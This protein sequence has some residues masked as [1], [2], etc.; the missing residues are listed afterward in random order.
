MTTATPANGR[1]KKSL[2]HQLDRLDQILD[3]LAEALNGAV[4][5]AV[6]EAVGAAVAEAVRAA[7]AEVL[8][9]PAVAALLA[10]ARAQSPETPAPTGPARWRDRL[11]AGC[12]RAWAVAAA[13]PAVCGWVTTT[14]RSLTGPVVRATRAAA[15]RVR[16]LRAGVAVALVVLAAGRRVLLP[17]AGAGLAAG[18]GCY[19][20][21]P[22]A[23]GL[24][25]GLAGAAAVAAAGVARP[26]WPLVL[27][28]VGTW[29][30]RP[31]APGGR[32]EG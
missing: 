16:R 26:L 28:A 22:V 5:D 27:A 6:K 1:A 30:G 12:R 10:E 23:A 24:V 19:L 25:G 11:R 31:T 21:G 17:A 20:A 14:A 15:G 2:E 3:G 9:N 13:A 8:T 29:D 32:P 7:L 18:V 4:A